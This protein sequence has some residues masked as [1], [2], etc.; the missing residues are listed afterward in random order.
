[1]EGVSK[2][3]I[4]EKELADMSFL[5]GAFVYNSGFRPDF[6]IALWRGGTPIGMRV[7]E[8][9]LYM[10]VKVDH[11]AIRT[12]SYEGTVSSEGASNVNVHSLNYVTKSLK[13]GSK[14]LLVDDVYE[15][16]N[17]IHAVIT[18]LTKESGIPVDQLDVRIATVFYKAKNN[19]SYRKPNYYVCES[20]DWLVFPHEVEGLSLEE[21]KQSKGAEIYEI[22]AGLK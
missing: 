9:F 17:S 3:F 18:K 5:L 7:H 4:S 15:T 2:R 13:P 22:F 10:K 14:V 19:R 21:I 6:L 12:S 11:V 20:N 8:L 16:G 1:M